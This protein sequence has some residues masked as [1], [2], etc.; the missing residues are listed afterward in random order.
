[1]RALKALENTTNDRSSGVAI[2]VIL[3]AAVTRVSPVFIEQ[4]APL[5]LGSLV[6]L[7]TGPVFVRQLIVAEAK[8]LICKYRDSPAK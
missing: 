6:R 2:A 4:I 8:Q 5:M 7:R 3:L 1:M